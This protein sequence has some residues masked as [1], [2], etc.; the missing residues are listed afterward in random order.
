M[1]V[2]FI[3]STDD[4]E[5]SYNAMRLANV[6]VKKGDDVS[7]FMLGKGVLFEKSSNEEFNVMEQVNQFEGDFYV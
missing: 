4:N 7:V 5:T 1:N 2:L 6:A 3:I